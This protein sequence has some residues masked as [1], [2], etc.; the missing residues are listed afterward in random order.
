M[1]I[2][3][4]DFSMNFD[5][6]CDIWTDLT[7]HY[8]AGEH[9]IFR[10]YHYERLKKGGIEGGIF[11]IWNDPPFDENPLERTRQM[12]AAIT[13]ERLECADILSIVTSYDEMMKAREAGRMYTFIGHEGLKSIGEDLDLI[14]DFYQFGARHAGLTWNEENAL[15]TGAR[16]SSD[17][18]LT[19]L[20]RRAVR[21]IQ[22][23]GMILDVSHLNDRSFWDLMDTA[24]GP[25]VATHSNCR[26][27]CDQA[28]NLT[29][30]QIKELA[31]TGGM[32]GINS[33]NEFVH[34]EE[35]KQTVANLVK[36]LVHM[37]D[38]IG[39]DHV[40]FGF[41]FDEFLCGDT[42]STFSSQ[43][44]TYTIGL[45]D[46]SHVPNII[47]EMR[48]VGFHEDEIEKVAYKNWH[49]MIR[50]IIG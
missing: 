18:G 16:G 4:G 2:I 48:R 15:A 8:L 45:E 3:E 43:S 36:H 28:R 14:D 9:D 30:E 6:H 47:E 29:D 27:L 12:Q 1:N 49:R 41:D 10:K 23:L 32:V 40:G 44:N 42:L 34:P 25:V 24:S 20:G 19:D 31:R 26:A 46:A 33:F 11:V 50:E 17:R 38:L 13:Q 5:A 21:K 35:D 22:D 39:I 37:V 7:H